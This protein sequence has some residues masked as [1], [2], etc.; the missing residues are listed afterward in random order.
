MWGLKLSPC[1]PAHENTAIQKVEY[2]S[3]ADELY[4]YVHI[5]IFF[6]QFNFTEVN[7]LAS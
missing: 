5:I 6:S 2:H 4:V 7:D 3:V 1:R